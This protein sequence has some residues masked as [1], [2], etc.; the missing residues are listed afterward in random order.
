MS[1]AIAPDV[2]KLTRNVVPV[3]ASVALSVKSASLFVPCSARAPGAAG[4][5]VSFTNSSAVPTTPRLPAASVTRAVIALAPSTPRSAV[6]TTKSTNVSEMLSASSSRVFAGANGEPPR[7]SSSLSPTTAPDVPRPTRTTIAVA[8]SVTFR[9][10]S[11][12]LL[13]NCS[14]GVPVA[15]GNTKSFVNTIGGAVDVPTLPA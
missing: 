5:V 12:N 2:P 7:S 14:T 11:D 1:P 10:L 3:A 8:D 13:V 15:V 9:M 6:E 4:A